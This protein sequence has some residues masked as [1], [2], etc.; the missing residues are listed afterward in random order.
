MAADDGIRIRI[1]AEVAA[2]DAVVDYADVVDESL[3]SNV[4]TGEIIIL[5]TVL[6]IARAVNSPRNHQY[7]DEIIFTTGKII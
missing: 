3:M 2:V 7:R 6:R 1:M 4:I 5:K